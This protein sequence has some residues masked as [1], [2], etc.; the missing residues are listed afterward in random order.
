MVISIF[1]LALGMKSLW[2]LICVIVLFIPLSIYRAVLE[3]R[4]LAEIFTDEWNAYV[5]RTWFMFPLVY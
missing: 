2:G 1:G 4:A 3:E 5:K